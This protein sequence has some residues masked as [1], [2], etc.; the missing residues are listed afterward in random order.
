MLVLSRKIDQSLRIGDRVRVTVVA[1]SGQGVRIAVEAPNEIPIYR[2]EL[3][4]RI[5]EANREAITHS[6]EWEP[7]G[8]DPGGGDPNGR[9]PGGG[10][11]SGRDPGGESNDEPA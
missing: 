9:D 8:R 4:E 10:D 3:Y 5:A 11:P 2:E 6:D 7:R 1:V